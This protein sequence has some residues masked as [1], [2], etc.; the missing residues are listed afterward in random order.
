MK[1]C[2]DPVHVIQWMTRALDRL[3]S[4]VLSRL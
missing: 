4:R 2:M 1:R 3:R